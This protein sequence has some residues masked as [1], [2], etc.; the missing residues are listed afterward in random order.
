VILVTMVETTADLLA[1]GRIVGT[2]VDARR[3]GDG[4]RADMA[5]SA[6]APIVN[7][8]PATAFAQNVGLVALTE[9]K[10]RF[11]VAVGGLILLVLGLSPLLAALVGVI[12]LPVLGGAGI[13]LFGIVAASGI[14]MLSEVDYRDNENLVLVAASLG[15]GLL[16]VV[17]SEFWSRFPDWFATIFGSGISSASIVAVGLNL[18]LNGPAPTA[19][20]QPISR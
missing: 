14:R 2:K 4:L 10:S 15:F 11:A 9:V 6:L 17:S 19:A 5:A 13:V 7:S 16:P 8:F 12:P 20:V 3:V 18:F 1:V